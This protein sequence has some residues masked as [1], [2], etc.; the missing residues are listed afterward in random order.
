[1]I[2]NIP[3]IIQQPKLLLERLTVQMKI[4]EKVADKSQFHIVIGGDLLIEVLLL[5]DLLQLICQDQKESAKT[6]SSNVEDFMDIKV[7]TFLYKNW[8]G[9]DTLKALLHMLKQKRFI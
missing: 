3:G 1:M 2:E 4:V 9:K 7:I 5:K 6:P 8:L